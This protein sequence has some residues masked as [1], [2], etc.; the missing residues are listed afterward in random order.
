MRRSLIR[1]CVSPPKKY[2]ATP[3]HFQKLGWSIHRQVFVGFGSAF[4]LTSA[5]LFIPF[6]PP[7]YSL[8]AVGSL[9]AMYA[10]WWGSSF[11]LAGA[12]AVT[13]A[14]RQVY[15]YVRAYRFEAWGEGKVR[16][17]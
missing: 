11:G 16:P 2:E 14:F 3:D 6:V 15:P 17:L 12:I 7:V 10:G 8:I 1:Y 4:A 9:Y 5:A 13:V